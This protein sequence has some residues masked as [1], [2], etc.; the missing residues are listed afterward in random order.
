[1]ISQNAA[2]VET[3]DPLWKGRYMRQS[4]RE[5]KESRD[6]VSYFFIK[7]QAKLMF[8]MIILDSRIKLHIRII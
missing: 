1:M 6:V 4:S 7:I 3:M 8:V 5:N 2:I